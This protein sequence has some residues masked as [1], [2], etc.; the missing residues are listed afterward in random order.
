MIFT[1]VLQNQANNHWLNVSCQDLPLLPRLILRTAAR[2]YLHIDKSEKA[3]NILRNAESIR[4]DPWLVSAEIAISEILG[5]KSRFIKTGIH[6]LASQRFHSR[7]TTELNASLAT[8]EY[9]HGNVRKAKKFLRDILITPNENSLAQAEYLSKK[10][11]V[12]IN[13]FSFKI[14]FKYE[15]LLWD[16]FKN[17]KFND[18]L[19]N[20]V[21]WMMYQPFSSRPVTT[22]TYISAVALFDDNAAIAIVEDACPSVQKDPKVLNNY[23]FSLANIGEIQKAKSILHKIDIAELDEYNRAV[24]TATKGLIAFRTGAVEEGRE[25]YKRAITYFTSQDEFSALARAYLFFGREELRIN[26]N[27]A[28]KY[29]QKAI[30]LAKNLVLYDVINYVKHLLAQRGKTFILNLNATNNKENLMSGG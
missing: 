23:A 26:N 12:N 10:M 30:E 19:K 11:M 16:E 3:V 25:L 24:L 27:D 17:G 15:A 21:R 13:P 18:A 2:F 22:A 8:L 4:G 7:S 6:I 28:A 1:E 20:S 29:L 14:P 5:L 9:A